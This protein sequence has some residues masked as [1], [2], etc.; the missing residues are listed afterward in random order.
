MRR[1]ASHDSWDSW[2]SCDLSFRTLQ[3]RNALRDAPRHKADLRRLF[4]IGRRASR[5]AC[6]AERRTITR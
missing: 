5:A 1:G 3:R 4:K 2:D 6:D